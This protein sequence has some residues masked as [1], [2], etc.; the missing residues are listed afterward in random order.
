ML[1]V[2][3]IPIRPK[4]QPDARVIA[5]DAVVRVDIMSASDYRG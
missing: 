5:F 1:I 4:N 2:G 3:M